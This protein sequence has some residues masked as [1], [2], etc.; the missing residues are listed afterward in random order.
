MGNPATP[1][2]AELVE[3]SSFLLSDGK[4]EVRPFDTLWAN[5]LRV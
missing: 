4:S 5:G 1:V 3:A 2:R